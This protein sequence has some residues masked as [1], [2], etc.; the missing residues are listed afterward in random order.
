[1]IVKRGKRN[2]F[3]FARLLIFAKDTLDLLFTTLI[4]Q[5]FYLLQGRYPFLS[6]ITYTYEYYARTYD[7]MTLH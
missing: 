3:P 5:Y 2:P 1:M 6:S 7:F 4:V